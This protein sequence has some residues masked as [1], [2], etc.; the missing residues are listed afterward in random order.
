MA[1]EKWDIH[2]SEMCLGENGEHARTTVFVSPG[3]EDT[4][5]MEV[6]V[7]EGWEVTIGDRE[8]S[9]SLPMQAFWQ[10]VWSAMSEAHTAHRLKHLSRVLEEEGVEGDRAERIVEAVVESAMEGEFGILPVVEPKT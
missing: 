6:D 3:T 4:I 9:V 5:F 2:G 7:D 8:S 10:M 1:D